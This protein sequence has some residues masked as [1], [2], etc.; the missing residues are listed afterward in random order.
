MPRILD[1]DWRPE[2]GLSPEDYEWRAEHDPELPAILK[3]LFHQTAAD[4]RLGT[5]RALLRNRRARWTIG[6][7]PRG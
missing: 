6:W 2:H 1:D 5:L 3:P 4:L 7:H